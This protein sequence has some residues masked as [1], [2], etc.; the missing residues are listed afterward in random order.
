ME[1]NTRF[2]LIKLGMKVGDIGAPP[3]GYSQIISKKIESNIYL[4]TV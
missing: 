4:K 2:S 1:I 3:G